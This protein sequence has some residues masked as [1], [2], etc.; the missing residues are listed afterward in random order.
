MDVKQPWHTAGVVPSETLGQRLRKVRETAGLSQRE[1][2]RRSGLHSGYLSQLE[3]GK[4]VHPSP[5]ILRKVAAAYEVRFEDVLA[6]AGY[7]TDRQG[8][9]P[10]RQAMALSTVAALGD[11]SD[12][13][14]EALKAIVKILQKNRVAT[15]TPPSDTPLDQ[16]T[17]HE[18][19]RHVLA[20]LRE[21]EALGK[22]PTPLEEIAQ[23]AR[24]VESGDLTLDLRDKERLT[25]RFG[26][27]VDLAWKRLQGTLD[28]RSSAY[29]VKPELHPMKQ[30]FVT[31][32]E[33][34]HAILPAH[35]ET[36][37]YIEDSST[38]LP[39]ARH[40]YEREA[41]QAAV[42]ILFQGGQ[43]TD[44]VDA[45]PITMQKICEDAMAFGASIVSTAR[46]AAET[47]R[48]PV[49][50]AIATEASAGWARRTSTHRRHSSRR[51]V[52]CA[53]MRRRRNC[54]KHSALVRL[55]R[56]RRSFPSLRRE[57]RAARVEAM[58]CHYW[59]IVLAVPESRIK[60]T[61]RRLVLAHA[62]AA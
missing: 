15:F 30:R 5:S 36:F 16:P 50:V 22:R 11:P 28:Y 6:W 47:S 59:S 62:P 13:E 43:L 20:L 4:I 9:V 39:H 14:L 60:R 27:W 23:A 41:N 38:L 51:S 24:L 21:A 31:S 44:E 33:I 55:E 7:A 32:H 56:T 45:S 34:G 35:R 19:R 40:L 26:R 53:A 46:Y 61:V 3:Q 2:E 49:A 29:W 57:L 10:P 17:Q 37:A 25:E 1:M 52:G 48:K 12:E 58:A 54:A 8:E 42:E 18:I